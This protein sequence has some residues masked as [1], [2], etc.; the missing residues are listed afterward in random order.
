MESERGQKIGE[1][2]LKKCLFSMK[3]EGYAYAIIGWAEDAIGFYEKCVG[4]TV[5][6]NSMPGVYSRLVKGD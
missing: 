3:E 5:I 4:A 1:A 2:L 6:E